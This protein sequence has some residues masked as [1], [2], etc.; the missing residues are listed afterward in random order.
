LS[1]LTQERLSGIL[2][3][4]S[5]I[6]NHEAF[7]VPVD[8]GGNSAYSVVIRLVVQFPA[9]SFAPDGSSEEMQLPDF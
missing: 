5:T 7:T 6:K 8:F 9:I 1:E 3:F 4:Y 2:Y